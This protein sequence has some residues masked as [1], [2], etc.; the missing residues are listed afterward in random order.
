[1][2]NT[3]NAVLLGDAGAAVIAA[4]LSGAGAR[5]TP[6]GHGSATTASGATGWGLVNPALAAGRRHGPRGH[7]GRR[8]S[9]QRQDNVAMRGG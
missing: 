6:Q 3:I 1:M 4:A 7:P 9:R 8:R 2:K 5:L